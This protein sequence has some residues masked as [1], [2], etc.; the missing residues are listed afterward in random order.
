M[1]KTA[2]KKRC[3]IYCL[4][5]VELMPSCSKTIWWTNMACLLYLYLQRDGLAKQ[6]PRQRLKPKTAPVGVVVAGKG[7]NVPCFC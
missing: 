7:E 4:G 5:L 3:A 2:I 1:G 6:Q